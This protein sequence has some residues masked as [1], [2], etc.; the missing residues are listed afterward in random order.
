MQA[1]PVTQTVCTHAGVPT[2]PFAGT[3]TRSVPYGFSL[4]TG[5][6]TGDSPASPVPVGREQ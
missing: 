2:Q 6:T 4:T 1:Y 5:D 3:L